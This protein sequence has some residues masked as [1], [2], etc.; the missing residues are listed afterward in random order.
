MVHAVSLA[1][2][3]AYLVSVELCLELLHNSHDAAAFGVLLGL[4]PAFHLPSVHCSYLRL[5]VKIYFGC[6][7]QNLLLKCLI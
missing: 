7:S 5:Q 4:L 6:V 1:T 2:L 3:V